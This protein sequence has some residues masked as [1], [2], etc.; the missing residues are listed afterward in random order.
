MQKTQ[1]GDDTFAR[2]RCLEDGC[3]FYP[4]GP[5]TQSIFN[6][7]KHM[8]G[9][10]HLKRMVKDKQKNA[11][12]LLSPAAASRA[13]EE[14]NRLLA[15]ELRARPKQQ[16]PSLANFLKRFKGAAPSVSNGAII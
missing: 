13:N 15:T 4:S 11:H 5:T 9:K 2:L 16:Q 7:A 6:V 1:C 14:S 12:S 3:D 8:R 10:D